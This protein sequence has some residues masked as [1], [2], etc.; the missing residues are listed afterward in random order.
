MIILRL[1][2]IL[3]DIVLLKYPKYIYILFFI[4]IMAQIVLVIILH[5][6]LVVPS[7]WNLK[8]NNFFITI[9]SCLIYI[10]FFV[11]LL[12]VIRYYYFN[13]SFDLK[14]IW[15]T[16]KSVLHMD[17]HIQLLIGLFLF[18]LLLLWLILMIYL[19][20]FLKFQLKRMFIFLYGLGLVS[21]KNG[22]IDLL[23]I[24]CIVIGL[25]TTC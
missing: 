21:K 22:T 17:L 1:F 10:S 13:S 18:S 20:L 15:Y 19:R 2:Q 12:I 8:I 3:G 11:V 6:N 24:L 9:I 7:L 14:E 23:I 25:M 16:W 4:L 5:K